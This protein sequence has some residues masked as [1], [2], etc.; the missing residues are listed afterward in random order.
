MEFNQSGRHLRR[1]GNQPSAVSR[2]DINWDVGKRLRI[3]DTER[4]REPSERDQC[5]GINHVIV[6]PKHPYASDAAV[7]RG[8]YQWSGVCEY[9]NI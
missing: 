2:A 4:D 7:C 6:T 5:V 9:G 1:Y 3:G 8:Q